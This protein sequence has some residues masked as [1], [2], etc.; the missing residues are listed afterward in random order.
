MT[1]DA[2]I[3]R[4][5]HALDLP[6]PSYSTPASAGMDLRA[7]I[8]D[9]VELAPG[10]RALIPTGI[11]IALTPDQEAQ[12]RPG[13]RPASK[14]GRS[15]LDGRGP[16]LSGLSRILGCRVSR[17]ARKPWTNLRVV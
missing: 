1:A 2:A 14:T 3:E 12:I 6:L 9:R 10:G 15:D 4:L 5:P 11:R 8:A 16:F 13:S 17:G 7:A